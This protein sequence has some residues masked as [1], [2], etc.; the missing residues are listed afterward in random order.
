MRTLFTLFAVL[1]STGSLFADV[2]TKDVDYKFDG[3]T[4]KGQLAWDDSFS[5]KRPGVLV[6]HEWWGLDEYAKG[7]AAQLA[8]LGYVAFAC[9]M[10]G[11]GA[12]AKHPMDAQKMAATTRKNA[13]IWRGRAKASLKVLSDFELTDSTRLA[14]MGYCFGG[15]TSLQL[16]YAGADLKAV[17]TFHSA[18]TPLPTEEQ[19]KNVKAKVLVCHGADD[20]FIKNDD[21]EKFQSALKGAKIPLQFESYPG[22]VH[23]FTVLGA[24]KHMIKGMAY[25][26]DADKKSWETMKKLFEEVFKK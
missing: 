1:I 8:K 26:A 20:S 10:Y 24:D 5:G 25:N 9:D 15:T 14:S 18:I 21:I 7:R 19:L 16:A 3:I 6:V 22:A 4:F 23:S 17:V 11:E 2:K 12:L 13:D